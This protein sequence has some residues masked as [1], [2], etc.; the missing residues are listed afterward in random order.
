VLI[1]ELLPG[2][3]ADEAGLTVSNNEGIGDLIIGIDGREIRNSKDLFRILEDY[4]VGDRITVETIYEG[5]KR[6]VELELQ[7]LPGL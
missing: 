6:E 3:A 4:Q 7:A 2:G 5:R 1:R